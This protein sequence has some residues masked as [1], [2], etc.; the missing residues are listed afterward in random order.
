M[1][2]FVNTL[3]DYISEAFIEGTD[4]P[5]S[6]WKTLLLLIPRIIAGIILV[7]LIVI[8]AVIKN[9]GNEDRC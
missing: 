3:F 9:F 1:L 5:E 8:E 4:Y 2:N 7:L 6:W